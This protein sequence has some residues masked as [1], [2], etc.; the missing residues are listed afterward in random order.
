M[1]YKTLLS[2]DLGPAATPQQRD[3]FDAALATFK[4][5][6]VSGLTATW[7]CSWSGIP[8]KPDILLTTKRQVASAA[9]KA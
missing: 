8:T 9:K 4:W 7:R 6:K 1:S 2:V 3:D 5:A